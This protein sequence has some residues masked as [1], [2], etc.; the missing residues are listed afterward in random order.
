[1]C[2]MLHLS[3]TGY[4]LFGRIPVTSRDSGWDGGHLHYFTKHA[5]DQ[6]LKSEGFDILAC[7]TTGG[8]PYLR[9]WWISL[10]GGELVY[11]CRRR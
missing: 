5:L 6:F 2:Q 7:K 1:M 3:Q 9:E 4:E 11:L 10:L 8:R